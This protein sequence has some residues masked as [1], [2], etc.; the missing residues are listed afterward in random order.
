LLHLTFSQSW[1]PENEPAFH[2]G[3]VHIE[4]GDG[5][6]RFQADL[7]QPKVGTSAI[8]HQQRLWELGDVVELFVQKVGATDYYE[9]QIA[10]NGFTLALH[11]PDQAA[12]AAVRRGERKMEEYLSAAPLSSAHASETS[13][14]W[15]ASITFP[16]MGQPEDLFRVSCGRYEYGTGVI[17]IISSTSP[18]PV[19]DFH[20]PQEWQEMMLL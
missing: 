18:H 4:L 12:V 17:P 19:R 11:Y 15:N 16:V 13:T 5:I 10:P 8:A 9:Y 14:G 1:L 20:R 3:V 7:N 6:L 2:P